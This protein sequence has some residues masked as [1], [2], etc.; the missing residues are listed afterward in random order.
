[1]FNEGN[2]KGVNVMCGFVGFIGN[3]NRSNAELQA[4]I[5]GMGN[6]LIH[7]GPD[8]QGFWNDKDAQIVLAH[9][10][11]SVV[12]LSEA[13]S[14]P[15][16]SK[17]GRFVLAFNGEIYNHLELRKFLEQS[18]E[19]DSKQLSWRGHSDTETLLA[20]LDHWGLERTLR[21][22]NGM[23]SFAVWDRKDRNLY[24]ARDRFGEKPLYYGRLHDSFVFGSELK[25]LV[26]HP[27]WHGVIDRD[28]L[29]LFMRY[30]NVPSPHTIYKGIK[31]LLPGNYIMVSNQGRTVNA[32]V[33]YWSLQEVAY[34]GA[35]G[36]KGSAGELI[37]ELDL[38]LRDAVRL[39][40]LSDVPVGAFLSG[41]YDSTMIVAQMQAQSSKPVRTF[42]IG[43]EQ[44]DLDEARYASAVANHLGTQHTELY[45]SSD[46]AM[47]IIPRLPQ[48]YDEPFADSSQIPTLLVS[49]LARQKVTVALSGD[50]GDELFA[51]YNRH[52]AGAKIW[53]TLNRIPLHF[54]RAIASDLMGKGAH[55]IARLVGLISG[56]SDVSDFS[57]KLAK[58][59]SAMGARDAF[60][61]YDLL[62][63][64]WRSSS[65][66]L[67]ASEFSG[68]DTAWDVNT[69]F[70]DQMLLMDMK[71]YL[72]DDILTKVDRATMAVSLEARVPFLDHRLVEFAWAVPSE[73]KVRNGHGKW[74]L[75]QVMNRYVPHNL[76]E[77]PKQG[78]G[79][80]IGAW[81]RGPLR[82]WGEE[83][84]NSKRLRQ[85]G[86]LD[87]K[88][89]SHAWQNHQCGNGRHEHKLWCVL[90]F[91][92]WLE[93]NK[94]NIQNV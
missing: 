35:A 4:T 65:V 51:G 44:A 67:N 12:D 31:K 9:Q 94:K 45:V 49:Q 26:L 89:V 8:D 17:S 5:S 66:V 53:S 78:F 81:L 14:Q 10:R 92:A 56:Q 3:G 40:M 68:F 61:F 1:L 93:N 39:R 43:N 50:G 54:R 64:H 86:F 29:A 38:L 18:N 19:L 75:R 71:T 91:Q 48:I 15:M 69:D 83:L 80:P 37:D 79:V 2:A 20:A 52:I 27:Q 25:A 60:E 6:T 47:S 82:E 57:L 90:M 22:L 13:G 32:P 88:Q 7:R 41:G 59:H 23:F 58:I 34:R 62:K 77:R 42:S 55:R 33:C 74:L 30:N 85:E 72:P 46:D 84:L 36:R 63:A 11:L 28:A 87:F 73:F 76:M 16:L 24:L 21:Q 70:L